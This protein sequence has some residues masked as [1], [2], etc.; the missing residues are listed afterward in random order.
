[1]DRTLACEAGNLGSTPNED[2]VSLMDSPDFAFG[3]EIEDPRFLSNK[4]RETLAC[5]D[6]TE[7][8]SS[9]LVF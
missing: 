3:G 8:K 2:T 6:F 5:A 7:V 9:I 4:N 1:M